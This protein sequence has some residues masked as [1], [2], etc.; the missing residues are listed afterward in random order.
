MSRGRRKL[1]E[2]NQQLPASRTRGQSQAHRLSAASGAALRKPGPVGPFRGLWVPRGLSVLPVTSFRQPGPSCP[3]TPWGPPD[4][5]GAALPWKG[6][7][8]PRR[9]RPLSAFRPQSKAQNW[10]DVLNLPLHTPVQ[11]YTRGNR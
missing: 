3:R 1:L 6:E 5:L 7:I 2:E 8:P 11:L 9:G 10:N 4:V